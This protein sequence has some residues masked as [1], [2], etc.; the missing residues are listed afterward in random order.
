[1]D[2]EWEE[3][4]WMSM[5]A[6]AWRRV[7]VK[8]LGQDRPPIRRKSVGFPL[9][10]VSCPPNDLVPSLGPCPRPP[11]ASDW[12]LSCFHS[13][14]FL[15][16]PPPRSIRPPVSFVWSPPASTR[17]PF[18]QAAPDVLSSIPVPHCS[19]RFLDQ[20]RSRVLHHRSG[21]PQS[22]PCQAPT[23]PCR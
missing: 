10:D 7:T 2:R 22:L 17:F 8:D 9:S 12:I 5:S 3:L 20:F 13:S 18:S 14:R 21:P 4:I 11:P 16:R 15:S 19:G 1:M 6:R 23:Q